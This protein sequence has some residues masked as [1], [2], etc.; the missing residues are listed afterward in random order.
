MKNYLL[1][2]VFAFLVSCSSDDAILDPSS[3]ENPAAFKELAQIDLGGLGASEISA[4]DTKSKRLFVVNNESASRIDVLDMSKFP[5]ITKLQAINVSSLGA[6]NSVSVYKG[7]LAVAIE[8]IN[9]QID[10][11]V[12][13]YNTETLAVLKEITVGAL[14]DM[15]TFSPDGKLIVTANEGEPN[16]DYSI[17]PVGSVS[18]IRVQ[19]NYAVTT[20]DFAGFAT[21]Q[22]TLAQRGFRVFGKNATL[23]QDIEPEYVAISDDSKTAWVTL[24]E[25]NGIAKIDLVS[26][27]ITSIF[28]LGTKDFNLPKNAVDVS[29][30]DNKIAFANWNVKSYYLP[31]AIGFVAIGGTPYIISAN[32]G[33]AREYTGFVENKRV[34]DVVLDP[35]RFPNA[36]TL[37]TDA[38]LGR[39][40][41]TTTAGNTDADAEFEELYSGG[42]RSFSIWDGNS[43]NLMFDSGNEM[44]EKIIAAQLYDDTRS[45]DKGVE[46]EGI[47]VGRMNNRNILFVGCERA[48]VVAIYDMTNPINPI[49]LQVLKTGDAPEGVLFVK[50]QD[51][52]NGKSILIVSS[53]T[54]GLVKFYQANSL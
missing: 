3:S 41:M 23:A 24:Q 5:S 16:A 50:A 38:N 10:G 20:L 17:D 11:K 12:V 49:F 48:D 37:Q 8:G 33:D 32:E 40:N 45:D 25:N 26:R 42:A 52:P 30:R 2:F 18:I 21:Q 47:A 53:E 4:Y 46:P 19:E 15:V 35:A 51:S 43:G 34:K 13:V 29:D 22:S 7:L 9:K 6:A 36:S 54:D 31:D 44:E 27:N 14:P 1:I 39:L 28:P